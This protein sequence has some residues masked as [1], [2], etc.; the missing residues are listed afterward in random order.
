MTR[1]GDLLDAD[2]VVSLKKLK[3][4]LPERRLREEVDPEGVAVEHLMALKDV[5]LAHDRQLPQDI[6]EQ[7]KKTV[8]AVGRAVLTNC[9]R[10]RQ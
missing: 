8:A 1:F 10:R 2:Q 4:S 9:F 5:C 6:R 7:L 3:P